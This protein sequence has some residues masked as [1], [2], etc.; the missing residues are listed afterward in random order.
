MRLSRIH[1]KLHLADLQRHLSTS[2]SPRNR[3]HPTLLYSLRILPSSNPVTSPFISAKAHELERQQAR[4]AVRRALM[5][6]LVGQRTL[7]QVMQGCKGVWADEGERV[8]WAICPGIREKK[9]YFEQLALS[10]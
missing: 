2:L 1:A 3:P 10:S 9:K 4:D 5:V 6:G 8:R 7:D